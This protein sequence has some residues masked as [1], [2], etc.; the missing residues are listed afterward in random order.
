[1][2]GD[3]IRHARARQQLL[4]PPVVEGPGTADLLGQGEGLEIGR[5]VG[6][7]GQVIGID[8]G[9]HHRIGGRETD[10]TAAPG[11]GEA[12]HEGVGLAQGR[13]IESLRGNRQENASQ[14][15]GRDPIRPGIEQ[16]LGMLIG[17]GRHRPLGPVEVAAGQQVVVQVA[18]D[19]WQVA[20]HRD[21]E[22]G[23]SSA[24]PRPE[25]NSK[26]GEPMAPA[27]RTTPRSATRV[28]RPAPPRTSSPAQRWPSNSRRSAR[29]PVRKV[30]LVHPRAGVR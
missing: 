15:Q 4:G 5:P 6:R 10:R 21:A 28:S 26:A 16:G 30:R 19:P 14:D 8:D 27:A 18:P 17:R 12:E 13:R 11:L 23:E 2:P 1:M 25:R 9:R 20:D 22:G 7:L 3:L 29:R 24:G